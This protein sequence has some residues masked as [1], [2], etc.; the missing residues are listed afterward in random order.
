MKTVLRLLLALVLLAASIAK[1]LNLPGFALVIRLYRFFPTFM[2]WPAAVAITATELSLGLWL[3][4][5]RKLI[6]AAQASA[7]LHS[8]YAVW[9]A[10]MLLRGKPIINCGCFGS[11]LS[12][13]L[14]WVT[15]MENLVLLALSLTLFILCRRSD[16]P[17]A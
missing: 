12:R 8:I 14:S 7:L 5:G 4:S 13:P 9:A 11:Y 2:V 1:L 17:S 6:R 15:V 10:F 3:L 16:K